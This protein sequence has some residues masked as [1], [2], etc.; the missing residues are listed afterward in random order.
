MSDDSIKPELRSRRITVMG[1]RRSRA[2]GEIT[3]ASEREEEG[4]EE[5]A[6]A[7]DLEGPGAFGTQE[8]EPASEI[9]DGDKTNPRVRAD[10][11]AAT[12]SRLTPEPD[13]PQ[14][15]PRIVLEAAPRARTPLPPT[16]V[17]ARSV[18]I[19]RSQIIGGAPPDDDEDDDIKTDPPPPEP[20]T[21]PLSIPT[22][23]MGKR[24]SLANIVGPAV[25]A[26]DAELA[27]Q[28]ASTGAGP[29][30]EVRPVAVEPIAAPPFAEPIAAPPFAEPIAA[31]PFAEPIAAPPFAEPIAVESLAPESVVA[32]LAALEEPS[33]EP[34]M[35]SIGSDAPEPW[36]DFDE[37]QVDT[38]PEEDGEQ[39]R[40][41][42]PPPPPVDAARVSHVPQQP[43]PPKKPPPPPAPTASAAKPVEDDKKR[44]RVRQWWE[45]FF[46]D[47]YLLTVPPPTAA[48]IS[49]QVDFLEQSLG[50]SKGAM[51]LDVG[52]GLGLHSIELARRGHLVVGLDLSLAMITRAAETAQEQGLKINFLHADIREI[53]FDGAF[54]AVIC[55]GTT[56]GFFDD[57]ANRDVLN[58]LYQALR[59]GGR[60]LL[61]VVN[62]DY[63]V[64]WQPN[65]VWFEG[66]GC[67]CMEESDFNYFNSRLVVKRTVMR[68]DGQQN[69][70][71]YSLRTYSLHELG[72]LTQALGF[73]VIEV[74]GQEA[75][76][77]V[78]FGNVSTRILMLAERR[79]L[80]RQSVVM[81]PERSTGEVARPPTTGDIPK[82][83]PKVG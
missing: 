65:L 53:A 38:E 13:E 77:G 10:E 51:V 72:Q 37:A 44:K 82:P 39:R 21:K 30:L 71:E 6:S 57:D 48:Q 78:F 19:G 76:R 33:S 23:S 35:I 34:P 8:I 24:P 26:F 1:R 40:A 81:P 62:R 25:A 58:R 36:V 16:V 20:R 3:E 12:L 47:E 28:T 49:R 73:R 15:N 32:D 83:P 70:S 68:E 74:S 79:P 59:P 41:N 46:S 56:F 22:P 61:D 69:N 67:V 4:G 7:S 45:R 64:R 14:T 17:M 11:I 60:I 9:D 52:C 50:L 43:S 42:T 63:V 18:V 75:T 2:T 5:E 29:E 80:Q 55:M 31:P 66:E 54:D 27:A